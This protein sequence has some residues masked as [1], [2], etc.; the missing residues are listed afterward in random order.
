MSSLYE[1]WGM[2]MGE[3]IEFGLPIVSFNIAS[4]PEMIHDGYNGYIIE[5]YDKKNYINCMLKLANNN[6][7]LKTMGK[8]ARKISDKKPN[9]M[10]AEEWINLFKSIK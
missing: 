5:N 9:E 1:G 4:A 2:V 6:T 10:I 3:A 7:L 8:N